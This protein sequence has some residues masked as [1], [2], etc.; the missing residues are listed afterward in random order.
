MVAACKDECTKNLSIT[1][2]RW[3]RQMGANE[4]SNLRYRQAYTFIGVSGEAKGHDER[5][6]LVDDQISDDKAFKF[7]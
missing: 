1:A 3:L 5:S 6:Y 4:I 2:K 7:F